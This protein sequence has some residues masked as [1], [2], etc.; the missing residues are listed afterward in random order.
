MSDIIEFE[1]TGVA[2]D[3][4]TTY[5]VPAN[6]T[7]RVLY[8]YVKL[9]TDATVANRWVRVGL[10]SADGTSKKLCNC[11]GKEVAASSSNQEHAFMQGIYRETSFI[12]GL[13]QVPLGQ[14]AIVTAG[15]KVVTTIEN[16]VAGDS[17]DV[18]LTLERER[19]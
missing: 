7:W 11:S 19:R 18:R 8:G 10:F 13:I 3:V 9:T 15:Q 6:T 12:N 5:T 1:A 16:G 4:D 2:G 17:Y 14:D